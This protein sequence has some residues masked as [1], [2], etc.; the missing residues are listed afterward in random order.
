MSLLFPSLET[1]SA[2]L[3]GWSPRH[4]ARLLPLVTFHA[5]ALVFAVCSET[6][7]ARFAMFL[8]VWDY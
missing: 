1:R 5:T 3:A 7:L 8:A 4:V 2:L 6:T